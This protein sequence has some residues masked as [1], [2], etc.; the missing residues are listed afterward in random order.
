MQ[1]AFA[2]PGRRAI[3]MMTIT[4]QQDREMTL[5]AKLQRVPQNQEVP[6]QV[7]QGR[8]LPGLRGITASVPIPPSADR[9]SVCHR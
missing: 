3:A 5:R 2:Q 6:D 1:T 7:V 4:A 8:V 9:S